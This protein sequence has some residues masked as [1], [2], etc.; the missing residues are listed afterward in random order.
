[1]EAD[2]ISTWHDFPVHP[3]PRYRTGDNIIPG[4]RSSAAVVH[5]PRT[6]TEVFDQGPVIMRTRRS[7]DEP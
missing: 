6:A 3:I 1:M 5:T 2:L 4:G 7:K